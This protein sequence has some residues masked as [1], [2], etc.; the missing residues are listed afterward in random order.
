MPAIKN[1]IHVTKKMTGKMKGFKSINSNPITNQFCMAMSTCKIA[2]CHKCYS[3]KML[4]TVYKKLAQPAFERNNK[5]LSESVLPLS[6]LPII[7][8]KYFRFHA[9]GEL[10][11]LNHITNFMNI[12]IKNKDTTFGFWTK[13]IDLV[14]EYINSVNKVPNNVVMIYSKPLIDQNITIAP[15]HFD[16]VFSVYTKEYVEKNK[17]K[18]NCGARNCLECLRCYKKTTGISVREVL[19]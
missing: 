4:T 17:V 13:R 7:K 3:T 1:K 14:Y 6:D 9:H 19:K 11:N 15:K 18:I 10:I 16:K 8:E 12:A 2:V 5:I